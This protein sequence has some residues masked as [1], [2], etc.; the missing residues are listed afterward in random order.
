MGKVTKY[1]IYYVAF[2][3]FCLFK[4]GDAYGLKKIK[5]FFKSIFNSSMSVKN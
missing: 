2:L 1:L 3:F 4:G 5:N